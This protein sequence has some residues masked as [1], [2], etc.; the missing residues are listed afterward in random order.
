MNNEQL[1]N[2]L[3]YKQMN[4]DGVNNLYLKAKGYNTE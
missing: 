2:D 3:Y 4:F 1:L